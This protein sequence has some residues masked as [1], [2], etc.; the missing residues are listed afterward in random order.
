MARS[1]QTLTL[2]VDNEFGVLTRITALVRREGWN[3]KSLAVAETENPAVSSLTLSVECVAS[4]FAHVT[5]RLGRLACVRALSVYTPATH[6]GRELLLARVACDA[7]ALAQ[8]AQ[9]LGARMLPGGV[10][11]AAG[12]PGE[13]D[14]LLTEL[15]ALGPVDAAR[16]G[17]VTLENTEGDAQ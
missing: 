13:I 3:I 12:A 7:A 1:T 9:R 11:E 2:M 17:I 10:L 4:T 14:A 5:A 6:T 15:R 8:A 16:S